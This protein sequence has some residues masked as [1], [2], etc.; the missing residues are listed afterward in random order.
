M[1]A[2]NWWKSTIYDVY[3]EFLRIGG[4]PN[5]SDAYTIN[6]QPGDLYPCSSPGKETKNLIFFK[7]NRTFI[8]YIIILV[9]LY[10]YIL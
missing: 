1:N 3:N 8:F 4:D 5:A 9:R 2:G 6:G 7:F 10:N